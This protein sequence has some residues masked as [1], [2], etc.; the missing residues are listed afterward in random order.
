MRLTA[1]AALQLFQFLPLTDSATLPSDRLYS[2]QNRD[3]P[4]SRQLFHKFVLDLPSIDKIGCQPFYDAFNAILGQGA[5]AIPGAGAPMEVGMNAS[6]QA[7]KHIEHSAI[8]EKKADF[9]LDWFSQPCTTNNYADVIDKIFDPL[10]DV[11][12]S[13]VPILDSKSLKGKEKRSPKG[14]KGGGGKSS[15]SSS[16]SKAAPKA[17]PPKAAAPKPKDD[18]TKDKSPK[19]EEKKDPPSTVAKKP[20]ATP[21]ADKKP[22]QT[23]TAGKQ[24]KEKDSKNTK[25]GGQTSTQKKT[26]STTA[27]SSTSTKSS[28]VDSRSPS[29]T[30]LS[31]SNQPV[32][33]K[34]PSAAVT[35]GLQDLPSAVPSAT[36]SDLSFL[37]NKPPLPTNVQSSQTSEDDSVATDGALSAE[38]AESPLAISTSPLPTATGIESTGAIDGTAIPTTLDTST[39]AQTTFSSSP[40]EA[41]T[42]PF[43]STTQQSKEFVRRARGPYPLLMQKMGGLGRTYVGTVRYDKGGEPDD[44]ELMDYAKEGYDKI[45]NEPGINHGIIMVAA[46]WIPRVGVIVGSKARE[47]PGANDTEVAKKLRENAAAWYPPYWSVVQGRTGPLGAL[48]KWHAEDTAIVWGAR[49]RSLV[50]HCASTD[51]IL[52]T[53]IAAYGKY[54]A[55]SKIGPKPP[56]GAYDPSRSHLRPDCREVIKR[57]RIASV[58]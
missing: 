16:S 52:G 32:K 19:K 11:P 12:D 42:C 29:S 30:A 26:S 43:D 56:C 27:S 15:G 45:R 38:T 57:L 14:G 35:T 18:K 13:V 2:R 34:D 20:T 8:K 55:A 49:Y 50:T 5:S 6:I 37:S 25:K 48:D 58:Y 23:P 46:L 47:G 24:G 36:L 1:I 7:A 51:L 3:V 40:S 33:S 4:V 53:M 10:K 22:T 44:G 41:V 21:K 28:K 54:N 39:I 31:V 9:F 17:A